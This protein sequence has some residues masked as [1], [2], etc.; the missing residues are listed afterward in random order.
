MRENEKKSL[1]NNE[2]V[3]MVVFICSSIFLAWI[4]ALA[5]IAP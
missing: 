2:T 3:L 1:L 5:I 4:S